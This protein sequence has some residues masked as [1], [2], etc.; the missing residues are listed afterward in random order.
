MRFHRSAGDLVTEILE[1]L[2]AREPL[3]RREWIAEEDLRDFTRDGR[4]FARA[5]TQIERTDGVLV[6]IR[7][8][9]KGRSLFLSKVDVSKLP[10][11]IGPGRIFRGG[12]LVD[13]DSVVTDAEEEPDY[14]TALEPT[15]DAKSA[16]P[17]VVA[18]PSLS[19]SGGTQA[20][21]LHAEGSDAIH[22]AIEDLGVRVDHVDP[23]PIVGP[24]VVR[25]RVFL[26]PGERVRHL[27]RRSEDLARGLA[28]EVF[29]SHVPSERWVAVDLPRK[30]RQV[31][32]LA[33]VL[34]RLASMD[35]PAALW[36]P[37]GVNPNGE[38]VLL[39]LT[40]VPHLLVAGGTGGGKSVWLR[41]AL[42]SLV[43]RYSPQHLEV[44]L[45]DPKGV[46][47][48]PFSSI[49]HLREGRII[50]EPEEAVEVLMEMTGPEL[51][52][53]TRILQDTQCSN[54]RELRTRAPET[55]AKY[56]VL[57][58]D[59]FADLA[60]TL[61]KN[62]RADFERQILRL[63]QRARAAGIFLILATQ[64][65]TVE[66]ITG[67]VKA[68]LPTRISF[69]LPQRV[70]SQVI[71]DEPGAESLLGSGDMLLR[72]D[73]RLQ[74]LQGYFASTEEAVRLLDDRFAIRA[75]K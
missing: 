52:R 53:R 2:G 3:W 15:D 11:K 58:V 7:N 36:L 72:H 9:S 46:D 38:P 5:L 6:D 67:A 73:G 44:L 74:R 61:E 34:D 71:L 16:R 64:R 19:R 20:S 8:T 17:A 55:D 21:S 22:C 62:Q 57:I 26:A 35:D 54:L 68:N 37:V 49:P 1:A 23:Q 70:D 41:S 43:L 51:A 30:D 25:H 45:V 33:A 12:K 10:A 4:Q 63:A 13:Q 47:Y 48:A 69:R 60:M 31:V 42:L 28:S 75:Q 59:E 24:T 56:L 66:F 29:V 18:R 50:T 27:Q 65:P 14:T 32:P 40:Q 39:D